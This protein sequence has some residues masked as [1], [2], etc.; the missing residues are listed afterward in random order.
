MKPLEN[1]IQ[2]LERTAADADVEMLSFDV[3]FVDPDTKAETGRLV[4]NEDGTRTNY[5]PDGNGGWRQ[6]D[7]ST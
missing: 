3:R 1:R 5:E 6:I 7:E 4:L 2:K